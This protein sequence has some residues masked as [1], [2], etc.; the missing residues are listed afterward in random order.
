MQ[1]TL[2]TDILNEFLLT[3]FSMLCDVLICL[4]GWKG[5]K[6]SLCELCVSVCAEWNLRLEERA[7]ECVSNEPSV[8]FVWSGGGMMG[9][10]GWGDDEGVGWG[11]Y[12]GFGWGDEG[13][14]MKMC[15]LGLANSPDG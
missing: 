4:L 10:A 9:L 12:G 2:W 6:I 8:H 13:V 5:E 7:W 15:L 11:D 3:N 1:G 14:G